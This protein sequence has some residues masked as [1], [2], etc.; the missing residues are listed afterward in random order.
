M[1]QVKRLKGN[2]KIVERRTEI[3]VSHLGKVLAF[4]PNTVD[5]EP[6]VGYMLGYS[7]NFNSV[8]HRIDHNGLSRPTT[9][10]IFSLLNLA[11]ENT[12]NEHCRFILHKLEEP[13]FWTATETLTGKDH[14]FV[15]DNIDGKMPREESELLKRYKE[16][17]KAVR[18]V[19]K[20]CYGPAL[21][22]P[23]LLAQLGE[24]QM[25]DVVKNVLNKINSQ[26]VAS[27]RVEINLRYVYDP[28][29]PDSDCTYLNL[30]HSN[31]PNECKIEL[32]F[33]AGYWNAFAEGYCPGVRTVK[34][35]GIINGT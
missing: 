23:Y 7:H 27:E 29:N 2:G 20:G 28:R 32:L 1:T 9:A 22:N 8:M 14:I 6:Y 15:Y 13:G 5:M 24:R 26:K 33:A 30:C 21:T 25:I 16:G 3:Y 19:K 34:K 11:L 10:Q 35:R 31:Y 17:D 18:I 12:E 4:N